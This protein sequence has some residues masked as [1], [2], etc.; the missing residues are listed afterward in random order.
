QTI[1]DAALDSSWATGAGGFGYA[2]NTPETAACLTL[3]PDMKSIAAGGAPANYATLYIRRSF[4]VTSAVD[5]SKHLVLTMDYDDG[6]V[7][8]LDGAELVRGNAGGTVGVEPPVGTL[9]PGSHE[10]SL[11]TAPVNL[12][13]TNDLGVVGGRLS[14]GTHTLAIIGMNAQ[15]NSSDFILVADLSLTSP[16]P[17]S[18]VITGP[19]LSMSIVRSNAIGIF[20]TNAFP[21]ST[22]VRINGSDAAF[23][24]GTGAWS[25]T[26]PLNPGCNTLVIEAVNAAGATLFS[27]NHLV[28]SELIS[29]S[30][31]TLGNNTT[32]DPSMGI[33]HVDN[34]LT[35]PAGGSLTINPGCV[36][37]L[38]PG[39]NV[40]ATNSASLTIN[41]SSAQPVCL[42]TAD[43]SSMWGELAADGAGSHLTVRHAETIGGAV[44][45]R[46]GATGLLEDSYFHDYKNGSVPIGGCTTA[47]SMTVRRCHFRVYHETLWQNTLMLV[48]DSLFELANNAS[49][50]ALDF[51]GA[52]V[53][54]EIRRCTFRHGPQSNTDAI[55]IGPTTSGSGSTNTFIHDNLMFDFPNDK[56]VSIGEG[57]YGIVVSNCL[58]YGNDSGVAVKDSPGGK[59]PCTANVLNCTIVDCDYGFRCYNKSMPASPTDGGQ[60]TNSYNNILWASR[61]ST[62]E[63]LNS[64]IVIADHS[65]FGNTNWPG[66]GNFDASPLFLNPAQRDYR[67]GPNSP[68]IGTGRN[69]ANLGATFPVGSPL[70]PSHPVLSSVVA[71]N[72][73]VLLGFWVDSEKNYSLQ[74]SDVAAGGSWTKV[75][76]VYHQMRPRFVEITNTLAPNNHFYRLV[77]PVQP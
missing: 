40:R 21:G 7:A 6:F 5:A 19:L 1:A 11:G 59:P 26:Q 29:T 68:C 74:T 31:A 64:G 9:A 45:G 73:Q 48:E 76:D 62:F 15:T 44:K 4:D 43:A 65:D 35:V 57:S 60:I 50:D 22:K 71:T 32:F 27:T 3:L 14:V 70:A 10:S 2:D 75:A 30:V 17:V 53:G 52:V 12:P 67:L 34:H 69:G 23:D 61:I 16:G 47:L 63:I 55:D 51:D 42:L 49:S 39:V 36:L 54:S 18:P 38:G 72:G 37:L 66:I 77:T 46:N 33:I 28:V 58:M 8:Y 20:G 41:G 24:L 56:G 13:S 25:K